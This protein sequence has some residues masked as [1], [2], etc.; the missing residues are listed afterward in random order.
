M[1]KTNDNLLRLND[2]FSEISTRYEVLREQKSKTEKYLEWS[3]ELEEKDILINIYNIAEYQK[4]LEVLLA[5]KRIKEQEK[6]ALEIKQ[7]ELIK[8]LEEIKNSLVTLDRTYLK[9]HDEE[10]ELIKKKEGLQSELNVIEERKNNRNLRSEKL[11]EDL[12]YLLERKE[13]LTK[14]L[15]ER[16]ELDSINRAKIKSLTKELADLEEGVEYN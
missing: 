7:E 1:E 4:K 9:Y 15:I 2:I 8:N 3:K 14:K 11:A 13:N 5:D 16:Q 6:T 10:L 12:K